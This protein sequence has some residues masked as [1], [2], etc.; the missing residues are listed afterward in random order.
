MNIYIVR[1]LF[2]IHFA[3]VISSVF[4]K[5]IM[6]MYLK[7]ENFNESK[8]LLKTI[9]FYSRAYII[10]HFY[11][12]NVYSIFSNSS[13]F[14]E[15]SYCKVCQPFDSSYM[16]GDNWQKLWLLDASIDSVEVF[17]TP[18]QIMFNDDNFKLFLS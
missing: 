13:T 18:L 2:N 12:W 4:H 9:V 17:R 16:T 6:F 11:A 3:I 10:R 5:F 7:S 8:E 1:K 14:I 15:P